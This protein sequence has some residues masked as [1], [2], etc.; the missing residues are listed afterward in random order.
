MTFILGLTGSIGMGKSTTAGLFQARGIPVHDADATVHALY[1]GRAVL[2]IAAAFPDAIR[3][4]AVDRPSLSAAVLGKPEAMARLEAIIHPLVRE[5]EEAFLR[6][7]REKGQGLAVLDVPLLLETGGEGRCDAVLVV[8]APAEVQRARVLAR[9][10]MTPE[11]LDAILARQMPDARKRARAHFIVDT[12]CGVVAAG[13]QVGSILA[14]L[15]GRPGRG[16]RGW[17]DD[18]A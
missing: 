4:G 3:D 10:G 7:C 6:R 17:T 5:E 14:A 2:L 11:R 15:A 12:S 13:R 1:R 16:G 9:A 8:S 18:H